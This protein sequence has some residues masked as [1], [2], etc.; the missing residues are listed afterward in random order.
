MHDGQNLFDAATSF[1]GVEWRADETATRLIEENK[2]EPLIIVAIANTKNRMDEYTLYRDDRRSA[3]GGGQ[4]YMKFVVDEVKPFIDKTY[5]TRAD[6]N[7][8]G[9]G[10]SSLGATISLE[11]CRAY[12]EQFGNCMAMSP[13]L[14]WADNALIGQLQGVTGKDRLDP[15]RASLEATWIA[16]CRFWIDVGTM[17][18]E[19]QANHNAMVGG[20]LRLEAILIQSGLKRWDG[21]AVMVVEGAQHNESAWADRLDKALMY[22]FPP[23]PPKRPPYNPGN[24]H[25]TP[26]PA[27]DPA[28]P[29]DVAAR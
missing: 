3:G 28:T 10:G 21:Y 22:L 25:S 9:V 15:R 18:G 17:E 8:S 27:P 6:R 4:A 1:A 7:S 2:I 16:S 11:I 5:R 20:L 23:E 29:H 12:P 26:T 24:G 13:A 14:G 19:T